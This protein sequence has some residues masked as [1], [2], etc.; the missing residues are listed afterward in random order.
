[1]KKDIKYNIHMPEMTEEQK[2][3]FNKLVTKEVAQFF[4]DVLPIEIIR[5]IVERHESRL[6]S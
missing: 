5:G 2:V 4:I 3:E 6:N 1:M